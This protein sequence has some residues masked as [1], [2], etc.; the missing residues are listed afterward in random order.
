MRSQRVPKWVDLGPILDPF[1]TPFGGV[2]RAAELCELPDVMR[3]GPKG[4]QG[5]HWEHREHAP[6]WPRRV[7]R[8]SQIGVPGRS[9]NDPFQGS[10]IAHQGRRRARRRTWRLLSL[11]LRYVVS[12]LR[13]SNAQTPDSMASGI[14]PMAHLQDPDPR[15]WLAGSGYIDPGS[16]WDLRWSR[17]DQ[18]ETLREPC[19]TRFFNV[20]H[21]GHSGHSHARTRV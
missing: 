21:V 14:N 10:E 8:G 16:W 11:P 18:S 7:S 19:A 13:T 6:P 9:Q 2:R 17:H 20:T 4:P 15:R 5:T 12:W 1:W 3:C